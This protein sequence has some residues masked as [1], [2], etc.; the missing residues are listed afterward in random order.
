[1]ILM[2]MN[3]TNVISVAILLIH[4]VVIILYHVFGYIGHY[5]YDDIQYAKLSSD[6]IN[7]QIDYND[8]FVYRTPVILLT[9]LSYLVFGINDLAS[10]LPSLFITIGILICIFF[11]LKEKG[12]IPLIIG[13]SLTTFS[14]W[15][16]FYSDKLMPDIYVAFF[17]IL[18]LFI[19]HS[20]K[21]KTAK[22]KPFLYAS[23]FSLALFFGFLS[24]GTIVLILPLLLYYLI[25]DILCKRDIRFWVYTLFTGLAFLVIYFFIIWLLTGDFFKRFD[26]ITSNSY[27][28]LCSYDQQSWKVLLKRITIDFFMLMIH[29]G[30]ITGFIFVLAFLLRRNTFSYYKLD[31]SFSFFLI[32]AL[33]LF[34]SSNFMTISISSYSPMCL[35]PRHYLFLIPVVAVPASLIIT[36]FIKE[37]KYAFQIIGILLL[38]AAIAFVTKNSSCW[39]LYLPLTLLFGIYFFIKDSNKYRTVFILGFIFILAIIP[40]DMIRYAQKVNYPEQREIINQHILSIN[41]D[42]YIITDEVQN[43]LGNYYCG[44][45]NNSNIHFLSY[46]QF[47]IDSLDMNKRKILYLNNYTCNLSGYDFNDLP[48]YA[49]IIDTA[50]ILLF[51]DKELGISIYEMNTLSDPSSTGILLLESSASFEHGVLPHWNINDNELVNK[52]GKRVNKVTEYSATFSYPVDSLLADLNS[53]LLISCE[54]QSYFEDKTEAML[55]ISIEDHENSYIW[56]GI[57]VNKYIRAYSNWQLLKLNTVIP[58]NEIKEHSIMKIYLWNKDK[59]TAYIDDFV[60]KIITSEN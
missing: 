35:D 51:A 18:S 54:L 15:F 43:R 1:M 42:C 40:F 12:N 50:N 60:I 25:V 7:G 32:S 48:Y 26:A 14:N 45:N 6:L 38:I 8:H 30:M 55:V 33:I 41:E 29:Q 57:N 23:L 22:K 39:K 4:I 3:R 9:A 2:K 56:K 20:Y 16:I 5:G 17:V 19:L 24:K 27:L 10:S 31:D 53:N 58:E 49:Q 11:L 47:D 36:G 59:K 28:N 21:F 46:H 13:L 37:K 52:D 34:L 44:F